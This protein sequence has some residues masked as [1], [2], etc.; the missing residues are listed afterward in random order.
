MSNIPDIVFW[1]IP[2]L[3]LVAF[4]IVFLGLRALRANANFCAFLSICLTAASTGL[5]L[6]VFISMLSSPE[7]IILEGFEWFSVGAVSASVNLLINPLTAIMI[8]IVS[9]VSL[10]V[11]IYS[12]GYMRTDTGLNRYFSFISLFTFAMLSLVMTDNLLVMFL[13][14]ELVGLCSYLLIGFWFHRPEA[15][16]AAKKAFFI[17]RIGDFGFL[18]ALLIL[19]NATG[20]FNI[21][22]I[23]H[24]A[25][26]GIISGGALLWSTLG[27]F[28][29][30]MGKSAQ[31]PLHT[32]LPDAME[33]P[34]PVSALIHAATM[35]ASGVFLVARMYPLFDYSENTLTVMAIIGGF[36]ALFAATMA[37]VSWDIKKV[38]AYS[39]ISQLGY[40]VLGLG[41]G[42]PAIAIFHL[43]TH[44][45]FKALLFMGAG[46]VSHATGTF[47]MHKMGGLARQMPWTFATFFIGALSL[48][49]IW[50][51]AGFFSKE[52]ILA[53]ALDKQPV[54]FALVLAT[55][56]LTAF[57]MFRVI[58]I[59][60]GGKY[61][62]QEKPR[63]SPAIMLVSMVIL[64]I[65]AVSSGWLDANGMFGKLLG[66]GILHSWT[67]GIFGVFSHPLTW[68]S[69]A[70]AAG[71]ILLAWAIYKKKWLSASS[72]SNSFAPIHSLL[73]N[74]YW[75]DEVNENIIG[76]KVLDGG[77][78]TGFEKFDTY[79][80]NGAVGGLAQFTN[81]TSRLLKKI[82]NGNLQT[83]LLFFIIGI[84]LIMLIM[85]LT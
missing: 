54:L 22:G 20:T 58:F 32:W 66:Q 47:D 2:G 26:V 69:L 8:A 1:L 5:S 29:G 37:L 18:A 15:A 85:V 42:G 33:G 6:W 38:L 3:P 17:T 60:F 48:S 62:G 7:T 59:T 82:Q 55:V 77:I 23:H 27:L 79:V 13:S 74:K 11:Q 75:C 78:F 56:F 35:V 53:S 72:I 51:L 68:V 12:V 49:G 65:L 45:F 57:Y 70:L 43:F 71:G 10:L 81:T 67:S 63:E 64:A 24:A 52:T 40:M 21:E 46:S 83:Y 19:F 25:A 31:F 4:L 84:A 30:A 14:W 61:K 76:K 16:K 36:T 28:F 39:T 41:V 34:T 9:V 50:P 73:V 44:A 80:I